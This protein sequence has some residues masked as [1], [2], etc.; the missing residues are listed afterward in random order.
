MRIEM[1]VGK[2]KI[3]IKWYIEHFCSFL[4]YNFWLFAFY[5]KTSLLQMREA[6]LSASYLLPRTCL[7]VGKQANVLSSFSLKGSPTGF[8]SDCLQTA[9]TVCLYI[10]RPYAVSIPC[11]PQGAHRPA[12]LTLWHGPEI[13]IEIFADLRILDPHRPWASAHLHMWIRRN[14][15]NM[16]H[17]FRLM[18]T[19]EYKSWEKD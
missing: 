16:L 6:N 14:E 8:R 4:S 18:K 15:D 2:R 10:K 3:F 7:F 5:R 19:Q 13:F 9:T 12:I 1:W 11:A 17:F